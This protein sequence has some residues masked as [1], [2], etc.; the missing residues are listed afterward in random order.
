MKVLFVSQYI[1]NGF[2]IPVT[3]QTMDKYIK[4]CEYEFICLNDAPELGKDQDFVISSGKKIQ[5][6]RMLTG[7]LDCFNEIKD[8]AN[9]CN[10]HHI[11]IPQDIH[12]KVRP[13][14]G[15]ARHIE[16]LNY[17]FKNID[18]LFPRINEFDYLCTIDSDA[19]FTSNI[20]LKNELEG[21]DLAGPLIYINRIKFYPHVGLFFINL[22]TV[23]NFKEMNFDN[24]WKDTGSNLTNFI[25]R[26]KKYKIKEIGRY[27]GYHNEY[28]DTPNG[29]GIKKI[30][31]HI[32]DC[33]I[34]V[35]YHLRAGSC[36][37]TGST[38]HRNKN[39]VDIFK[40]KVKTLF[41]NFNITYDESL[42]T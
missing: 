31:D 1:N 19:F 37:G 5:F 3:K 2:Y 17:F 13:N 38:L 41:D 20:D 16:I 14:H 34:D 18:T 33:W 40:D 11:K 22:K 29:K 6:C 36:F 24:I 15:G 8:N 32:I 12:I 42:F 28:Y 21:Y 9:K 27:E 30:G 4:N 23:L 39:S 10:F 25:K 35:V 7:D 26:N